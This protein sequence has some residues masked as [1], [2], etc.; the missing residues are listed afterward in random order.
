[1]SDSLLP[2][3]QYFFTPD[4]N[5]LLNP[6]VYISWAGYRVCDASHMIGPR[7]L[8]TYKLVF[9]VS[10]QGYLIQDDN[11]QILLKANDMFILLANH[12]HHYWADPQNPWTITWVAFNGADSENLLNALQLSISSYV[13]RDVLSDSIRKTMACLLECLA[14]ETD[15]YRLGAI[16]SLFS[17]FNKLRNSQKILPDRQTSEEDSIVAHIAGFIEQNYY[18]DIDMNMLCQH[19]H[20]SRSYLARSFKAEMQMTIQ[21]FLRDTRINKAISLLLETAL[22]IQEVSTSVGF[23]DSLYFSKLF[24]KQIGCSPREYRNRFCSSGYRQS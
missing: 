4:K 13:L 17:V 1:M 12:R 11:T 20:Y 21:D 23:N 19:I 5:Y 18:M 6:A 10:G 2:Y 8:D 22:S 14:D 3:E 24:S 7:V 15:P 16:T 9:I